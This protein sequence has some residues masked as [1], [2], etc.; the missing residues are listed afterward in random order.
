M[1]AQTTNF[2]SIPIT[3]S[4]NRTA[5]EIQSEYADLCSRAGDMQYRVQEH[6]AA[7]DTINQRLFDLNK[8][9]MA[10]KENK[11]KIEAIKE[12][13]EAA[14]SVEDTKTP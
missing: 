3:K 8:E 2:G 11:E 13:H 6:K 12:E 7:L 4:K 10:L 5:Q 1:E 14:P 9:F